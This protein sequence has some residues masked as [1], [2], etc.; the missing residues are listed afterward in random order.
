M[1]RGFLNKPNAFAKASTG[2]DSNI[3]KSQTPLV[4]NLADQSKEVGGLK[5][6]TVDVSNCKAHE[7]QFRENNGARLDY[8][9]DAW[10]AST[11][12]S[13]PM[14]ATLADVPDG[15][16]ECFIT[17]RAKRAIVSVPGFP[18]ALP[19]TDPSRPKPYTIVESTGK[20]MGMFAARDIEWGELIV[21]ERP[22]LVIPVAFPYEGAA[23]TPANF[24]TDHIQQLHLN[25]TEKVMEML[26][27]RMPKENQEAYK[28][29][30]NCHKEDGSGP[31]YGIVRTNG[32]GLE[33]YCK[34][35]KPG[36][37]ERYSG[38]FKDLSRINHRQV[39]STHPIYH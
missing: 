15:W 33:D 22:M 18:E 16:A 11:Q 9:D 20:G 31:L 36:H 39:A 6:A 34:I 25:Q 30:A 14:D 3:V 26:L 8:P 7:Y 27:S 37:P 38:I 4:I 28:K 21:A 35:E 32:F 12:P 23:V 13:Q 10:L 24:T 2:Y 19:R 5:R 17:G 29:L 1:K